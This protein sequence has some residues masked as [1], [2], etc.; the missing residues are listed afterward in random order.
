M[1]TGK[2]QRVRPP[3]AVFG[4]TGYLGRAVVRRLLEAGN[5]V[6]IAARHPAEAD[7]TGNTEGIETQRVDIRDDGTVARAVRDARTAV[8]AVGLYVEKGAA[9]FEAVHVDG[10]ARLARQ[11][12][13]AGVP[14]VHVSGIGADP[15][16][17]SRYVAARGRGEAAVLSHC[18][19]AIIVRPGVLVGPGSGFLTALDAVTRMP[20]VP[21]FGRGATRLQPVHVDDVAAAIE[22]LITA[23]LPEMRIF[24]LGGGGIVTYRDIVRLVLEYYGRRRLLMPVPFFLWKILATAASP[25]PGPPLSLEQVHLMEKDNITGGEIGGFADLGIRPRTFADAL[26]EM[27]SR[28]KVDTVH[29]ASR[30]DQ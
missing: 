3:I 16:S 27:A 30:G 15:E 25:L 26:E 6:R 14:L 23:P 19:D 29:R 10:A 18:P 5:A 4:G 11:T 21:L 24:E 8:S 20:L 1:E 13:E 17:P 2:Q 9:T 28:N 12:R 22:R 7:I